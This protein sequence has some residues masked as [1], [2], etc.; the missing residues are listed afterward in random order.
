MLALIYSEQ[1]FFYSEVVLHSLK[2]LDKLLRGNYPYLIPWLRVRIEEG[3]IARIEERCKNL[4]L[5]E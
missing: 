1:P 5:K 3:F 4:F 2:E